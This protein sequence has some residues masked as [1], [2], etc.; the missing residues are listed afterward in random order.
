MSFEAIA[1]RSDAQHPAVRSAPPFAVGL[2]PGDYRLP[3][4]CCDHGPRDDALSV[5]VNPDG[6][7]GVWNCWR[8][9]DTGNWTGAGSRRFGGHA[10]PVAAPA[11]PDRSEGH[12]AAAERAAARCAAARAADPAHP[13]LARKGVGPH[14]LRQEGEKLLVPMRDETGDI[15]SLQTIDP[16]GNKQFMAGG[17]AKGCR[18]TIGRPR[19]P[20]DTII[21]CEGVATGA[22]IHEATGWAVVVAFSAGN[23]AAVARAIRERHPDA[24]IVIAA[25]N[26]RFTERRIRNPGIHHAVEAA[27]A[28][29]A[30]IAWPPDEALGERGTD[31]NDM[32]DSTMIRSLIEDAA[33]PDAPTLPPHGPTPPEAESLPA[34]DDPRRREQ[35][36]EA[37]RIGDGEPAEPPRPVLF[38]STHEMR[39][40]LV[41]VE[42]GSLVA[43]RDRPSA[44]LTI[45]EAR[46]AFRASSYFVTAADESRKKVQMLDEWLDDSRRITVHATTGAPGRGEFVQ[47]PD[48]RLALN[49]WRE[50]PHATPP[51]WER[52]AAL[53]VEH[54]RWLWGDAAER[55]LNWLAHIEQRP[56]ILPHHGWIHV[57]RCFGLGR[58]WISCVLA[59]AW[60]GSVAANFNLVETLERGF[61]GRLGCKLLAIV[62]EINEGGGSKWRHAETLKSLITE[63]IRTVN[64]KYGRQRVEWNA[65]RWLLFSNHST[66]LPLDDGDRR[67]DVA[68]CDEQPRPAAY[69]AE[70]YGALHDPAL[71]PSVREWLRR[72][73]ISRFNP[74]AMPPLS[75]AKRRM[76]ELSKSDTDRAVDAIVRLW[77]SD[78]IMASVLR[79]ACGAGGASDGDRS[80]R[81]AA[82]ASAMR[83]LRHALERAGVVKLEGRMVRPFLRR[84]DRSRQA[85][86]AL[87]A[88]EA[89]YAIR[90][91][92]IWREAPSLS[93]RE[94][95]AAVFDHP[96]AA[97]D[98]PMDGGAAAFLASLM[99]AGEA[100]RPARGE[101]GEVGEVTS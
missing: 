36:A 5:T 28:I 55:F 67:F 35:Q 86:E 61:N 65:A 4:P 84:P 45:E 62:D 39:G 24:R 63:E 15:V 59:R 90:N 97:L 13:Y 14:G 22:T 26:D 88:T 60:P 82:A 100:R 99:E 18:F 12:A 46:R 38:A 50:L 51:G 23:L 80:A 98:N 66:A 69:Y 52:L 7:S 40:R 20:S 42:S 33:A 89:V 6:A 2:G 78:L 31:F 21:V 77:P 37:E 25:D 68:S 74:G 76:I 16:D 70:L 72:R 47:D 1:S 71:G 8:C 56:A 75:A 96:A 49:L 44:A 10:R 17:R 48:G 34:R 19:G 30:R 95:I 93:L 54:V 94:E 91:A 53:F 57:A 73:D 92:E 9:G 11:R 29:G 85:T 27:R 41:Y 64:P 101:V 43:L 3:C 83:S 58:N 79:A 32:T 87:G 81:A